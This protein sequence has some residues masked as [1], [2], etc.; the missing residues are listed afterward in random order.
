M[1]S[2]KPPIP[3]EITPVSLEVLAYLVEM[4]FEDSR[5]KVFAD[6]TAAAKETLT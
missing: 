5:A 6:S 2:K 4:R 1:H 3:S